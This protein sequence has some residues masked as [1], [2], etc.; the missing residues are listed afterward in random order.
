MAKAYLEN[1]NLYN[2]FMSYIGM[3]SPKNPFEITGEPTVLPG[4]GINPK[5]TQ[6][7]TK[8][9]RTLEDYLRTTKVSAPKLEGTGHLRNN[10]ATDRFL[11][12]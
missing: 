11:G 5:T 6:N 2:A 9:I 4:R 12:G 3:I 7:I 1:G 8:G 10:Y